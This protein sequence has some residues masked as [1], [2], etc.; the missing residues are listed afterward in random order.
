MPLISA[1]ALDELITSGSIEPTILDIRWQ[2]AT[3]ADRDA[4][5]RGHI[6]G[7]RFIDLDT[8]L[9]APP[10]K[11]GR[12]PLPEP[13]QFAADMRAAGVSDD[14]P[15]V[16]YDAENATAAARAWWLLRYFGH[17]QVA[18]LDGGLASW[19]SAGFPLATDVPASAPGDFNARPGGMR[20]VDADGAAALAQRGVLLDARAS[21]RFRG[22]SEPVDAVAGHI[23]GARNL[24]TLD[25]LEETRRFREPSMLRTAF[26]G[27]GVR[28]ELD[29]GAYCGSGVTAAHE[30]L[31]LELAGY[32][33]ALYPGS[34]SEWITDPSR[35]VARE[36]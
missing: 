13:G 22:T 21:E 5:E 26:E 35:P 4:Y 8:Q 20:V 32:R 2:L 31:A 1:T 11:G 18:V 27:A 12:H 17:G 9:A 19:V 34:W 16:V 10:G 7:A 30:V 25:N 15:V 36:P 23:P 3:G 24:P 29:V 33:A 14:R 28:T 6:P